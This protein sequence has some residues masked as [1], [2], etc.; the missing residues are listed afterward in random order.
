MK[1]SCEHTSGSNAHL[2]L[3]GILKNKRQH[4]ERISRQLLL[5]KF[6]DMR[7]ERSLKKHRRGRPGS[8]ESRRDA[9]ACASHKS[10]YSAIENCVDKVDGGDYQYHID[11]NCLQ[12]HA[13]SPYSATLAAPPYL[14]LVWRRRCRSCAC[15]TE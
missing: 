13:R 4:N 1:T 8:P 15:D 7:V 11:C 3:E 6:I 9:S 10:A 12:R 5:L 14:R 2:R